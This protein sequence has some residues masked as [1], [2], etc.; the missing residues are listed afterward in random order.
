MVLKARLV[1]ILLF[2]NYLLNSSI[3]GFA[4]YG[5]PPSSMKIILSRCTR[6]WGAGND[7]VVQKAL[8]AFTIHG[9]GDGTSRT[10]GKMWSYNNRCRQT[11][12]HSYLPRIKRYWYMCEWIFHCPYLAILYVDKALEIEIGFVCPQ[13]VP[14]PKVHL[15]GKSA[16][17]N[18]R[19]W[20]VMCRSQCRM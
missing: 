19:T 8:V 13:N 16:R 17:S 15:T 3:T 10:H 9:T 4:M 20:L 5:G 11:A 18:S 14:W 6:C 7:L 2:L 1:E 12:P